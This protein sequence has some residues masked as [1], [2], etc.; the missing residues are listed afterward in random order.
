MGDVVGIVDD[1]AV[2]EDPINES[3]DKMLVI[4]TAV[5]RRGGGGTTESKKC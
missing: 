2:E 1:A 4:A 3:W 5:V